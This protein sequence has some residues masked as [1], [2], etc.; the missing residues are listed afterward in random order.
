MKGFCCDYLGLRSKFIG[1]Y[2]KSFRTSFSPFYPM[3]HASGTF[4]VIL[5]TFL[6]K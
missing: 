6:F 3:K 4:V 5:I 2:V 1:M